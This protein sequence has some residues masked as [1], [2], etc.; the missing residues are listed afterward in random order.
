VG[1]MMVKGGAA[2]SAMKFRRLFY[3]N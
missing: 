3:Q 2:G 1:V